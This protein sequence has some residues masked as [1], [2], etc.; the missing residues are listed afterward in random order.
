MRAYFMSRAQRR[1]TCE[2]RIVVVRQ[3]EIITRIY[4]LL[5]F[6]ETGERIKL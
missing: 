3:E 1:Q 4:D 2:S 5:S 6:D